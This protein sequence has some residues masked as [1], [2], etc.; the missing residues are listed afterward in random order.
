MSEPVIIKIDDDT[1]RIENDGVRFFLLKGKEKALLI[2][3]GMNVKGVRELCEHLTDLPLKLINTHGDIDHIGGN[4]DFPSFMMHPSEA[5]NY[6]G[7]QHKIGIIDPVY[8]GD[9][10]DLG[11]RKLEVMLTPGHTPGS[12]MLLDVSKGVVYSG[13][14]VQDG[15]IFLFGPMRDIRAYALGLK[16]LDN[17]KG[18]FDIIYP[19]HGSF[20]VSTSL[21]NKL[22]DGATRVMRHEVEG[23][24]ANVF[25][26]EIL[27]YDVG[28]AK[29]LGDCK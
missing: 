16:R 7:L 21:V 22:I 15:N 29:I 10:I 25:G 23:T 20:P 8:D 26:H 28:C 4:D 6:Y 11:E 27:V 24:K 1:W 17:W 9:I 12:I 5:A 13:D 2:D 3:S 18:R 19:S 14:S